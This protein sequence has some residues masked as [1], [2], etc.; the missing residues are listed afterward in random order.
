MVIIFYGILKNCFSNIFCMHYSG[1]DRKT[2]IKI[3]KKIVFAIIEIIATVLANFL[4]MS[5]N[6]NK[7]VKTYMQRDLSLEVHKAQLE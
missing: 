6:L 5:I 1:F 4:L 2:T 3:S 7:D